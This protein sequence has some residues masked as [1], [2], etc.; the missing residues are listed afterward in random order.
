[1]SYAMMSYAILLFGMSFLFAISD[2]AM[3]EIAKLLFGFLT[4]VFL[5]ILSYFSY[6]AERSARDAKVATE[7]VAVKLDHNTTS[8]NEKLDDVAIGV[9]HSV[10]LSNSDRLAGV[11]REMESD[12]RLAKLTRT[13]VDIARFEATRE[14]YLQMEKSQIKLA[15][16]M[17]VAAEKRAKAKLRA[18]QVN[19]ESGEELAELKQIKVHTGTMAKKM[20]DAVDNAKDAVVEAKA[21]TVEAKEATESVKASEKRQDEK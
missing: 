18:A 10:L 11:K 3:V 17:K 14:H 12:E 8:T 4:P 13:E 1:M 9:E 5:G 19:G 20:E 2:N 15:E 7:Q 6:K 16:D 21:A